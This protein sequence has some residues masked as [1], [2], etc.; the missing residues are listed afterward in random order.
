MLEG[1]AIVVFDGNPVVY[2]ELVI[3]CNSRGVELA[4][5]SV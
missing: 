1:P 4:G 3:L 5:D 2:K